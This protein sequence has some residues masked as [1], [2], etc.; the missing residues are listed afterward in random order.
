MPEDYPK[1]RK[2]SCTV[3]KEQIL[4]LCMFWNGDDFSE[5]IIDAKSLKDLNG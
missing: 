3:Q 2:N 4:V 1:D 5:I